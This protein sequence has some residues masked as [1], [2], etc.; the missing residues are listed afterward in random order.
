MWSTAHAVKLSLGERDINSPLQIGV[1]RNTTYRFQIETLAFLN[2][3]R[4]VKHVHA[5]AYQIDSHG[6]ENALHFGSDGQKLTSS[7]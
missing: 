5:L 7:D 2:A 6:L 4:W 1:N 3:V